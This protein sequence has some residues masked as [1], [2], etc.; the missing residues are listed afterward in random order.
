M[1]KPVFQK[2]K[3]WKKEFDTNFIKES[4]TPNTEWTYMNVFFDIEDVAI[5]SS[6]FWPGFIE[7]DGMI[8]IEERLTRADYEGF[9]MECSN[10]EIETII[11]LATI[12]DIFIDPREGKYDSFEA[13]NYLSH[14]MQI[15]WEAKLKREFPEREFVVSQDE[16]RDEN[17]PSVTFWQKKHE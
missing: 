10:R 5:I 3:D 1:Q 8:F 9:R 11:N 13:A 17:G 2:F 12:F 4:N 16:G 6:L 15:T 7:K 14:I